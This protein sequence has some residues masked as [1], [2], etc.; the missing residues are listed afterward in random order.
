M[1]WKQCEKVSTKWGNSTQNHH[2][3]IRWNNGSLV[4]QNDW[5]PFFL[6][7]LIAVQLLTLVTAAS[8]RFLIN[9]N[10]ATVN[11]SCMWVFFPVS[12]SVQLSYI[13]A[14]FPVALKSQTIFYFMIIVMHLCDFCKLLPMLANCIWWKWESFRSRDT[15]KAVFASIL[16]WIFF[17]LVKSVKTT[18]WNWKNLC[19]Y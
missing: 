13:F 1:E 5:P 16:V 11:L 14:L 4:Q 2:N 17:I 6:L 9:F 8:I 10:A 18:K 7:L 3:F 15:S 12:N 19:K